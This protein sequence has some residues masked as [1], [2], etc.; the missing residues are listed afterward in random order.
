VVHLG[1]AHPHPLTAQTAEDIAD[2]GVGDE[3]TAPDDDDAVGD[4]LH[5][6]HQV[7]GDQHGAALVGEAAQQR[8]DPSDPVEVE[9]VDRFVEEQDL[10]VAQ[11]RGGDSRAAAACPGSSP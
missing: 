10:R 5:L 1:G 2:V 7:T 8:T 4:Q 6:T 3:P 9:A 11:Q